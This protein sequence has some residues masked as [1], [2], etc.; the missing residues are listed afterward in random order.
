MARTV[1]PAATAM[2]RHRTTLILHSRIKP[3]GRLL[4]RVRNHQRAWL[5]PQ[6]MKPFQE[7]TRIKVEME[8]GDRLVVSNSGI[9]DL[10]FQPFSRVLSRRPASLPM[11]SRLGLVRPLSHR[12]LLL[13]SRPSFN[14]HPHRVQLASMPPLPI[15]CSS[16]SHSTV[17]QPSH[18]PGLW[19]GCCPP[20]TAPKRSCSRRGMVTSGL[21][22]SHNN[23][24][25]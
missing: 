6:R 9:Q 23:L 22:D 8:K 12:E 10:D 5:L 3:R 20:P 11:D 13:R 1:S 21:L 14:A 24:R 25:R 2:P 7:S 15:I 17:P 4:R 19:R 18:R 16:P